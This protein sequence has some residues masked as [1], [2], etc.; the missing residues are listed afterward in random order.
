M[1][2]FDAVRAADR[3][4]EA[5]VADPLAQAIAETI[6]EAIDPPPK[7]DDIVTRIVLQAELH[8]ALHAQT[9][10]MVMFGLGLAAVVIAAIAGIVAA[11][12]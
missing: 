6:R 2:T 9:R 10:W 8:A 7:P 3:L 1:A 5:G 11:Q 12:V 4:R